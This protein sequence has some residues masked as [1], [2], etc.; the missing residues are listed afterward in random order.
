M[1]FGIKEKSIILTHTMYCW[2]LIRIYPW[3]LWLVLWSRVTYKCSILVY[4]KYLETAQN[5]LAI[6]KQYVGLFES[7]RLC[8]FDWCFVLW[9][10]L[11]MQRVWCLPEYVVCMESG[12]DHMKEFTVTCHLEGLEESG[13][14]SCSLIP[15]RLAALWALRYWCFVMC[16][17]S[18]GSGSSKKLARR[19]AA[20]CML[21]KLQSLSGSPEINWVS[22]TH[23]LT[24]AL[25]FFH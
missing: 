13:A 2:K 11:A 22:D 16:F 7:L 24:R 8:V 3:Y 19:A 9:Q 25:G 15:W 5:T 10:E 18:S 6:T 20:E 17:C 23:L 4:L 12:P 1:I 21:G 14:V